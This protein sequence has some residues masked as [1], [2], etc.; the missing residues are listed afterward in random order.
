MK[1][2]LLFIVCNSL[3]I[4]VAFAQKSHSNLADTAASRANQQYIE[5]YKENG[6]L[7]Y[8][9]PLGEIGAPSKYVLEGKLTTIYMLLGTKKLPIAFAVIPDFTVRVRN[10][11]SAGVR[12]PSFRLGGLAYFRLNEDSEHYKYAELGF[13]HHSNGQ[14]GDFLNPDQSINTV[15]GNFSTN[16]LTVSY[17]YGNFTRH[18]SESRLYYSFNNR[19]GLEWHKWFNY[20]QGLKNDYGFTRFLYNFSLR[21]YIR[22]GQKD[23]KYQQNN[24]VN[25]TLEKEALRLSLEISYAVNKMADYELLSAQKR[26][27]TEVSV[28]YSFPFMHNAFFMLASGY[29]GEDP[30]NI[31]YRDRYGYVRFGI[32]TGLKQD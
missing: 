10:E 17:R 2:W 16:Y 12:T 6:E 24:S 26:L 9:S 25:R 5:R 11:R 28:N 20:E 29:Y 18:A 14:D 30:Y 31:Y 3:I 23:E 32:S 13:T 19:F 8:T 1:K 22:Y 7:S 21:R 4:P 27:N 15:N